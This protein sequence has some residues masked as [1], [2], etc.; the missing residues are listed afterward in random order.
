MIDGLV[1]GFVSVQNRVRW[2]H[3]LSSKHQNFLLS[4]KHTEIILF[5]YLFILC[6]KF[7]SLCALSTHRKSFGAFY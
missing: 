3:T 6:F 5:S 1:R 4:Q 2:W 7:I